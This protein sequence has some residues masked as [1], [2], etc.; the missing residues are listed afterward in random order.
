[1]VVAQSSTQRE[2]VLLKAVFT[3]G[4]AGGEVANERLGT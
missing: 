2:L 3:G 4:I 1:M